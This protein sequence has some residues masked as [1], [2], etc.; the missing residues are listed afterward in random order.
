MG[1]V[2]MGTASSVNPDFFGSYLG[3]RNEYVDMSEFTRRIEEG[4]Y[5]PEEYEKAYQWI[6][7]F[8]QGQVGT[9]QWRVPRQARSWWKFVTKMTLIARDL[10]HGNPRLAELGFERRE[11][12]RPRGHR[13]RL[14]G[15]APVDG[16]AP[17]AAMSWRPHHSKART[18][19]LD[20]ASVSPPSWPPRND[21]LSASMLFGYR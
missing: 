21:S 20:P 11:A 16:S 2:S 5:D 8:K 6:A 12:G 17:R 15:T 18:S 4:I 13:R 7:N 10:M 1:S 14:P 9:R 19:S 3:M